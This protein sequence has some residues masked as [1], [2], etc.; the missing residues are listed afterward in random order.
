MDLGCN[1]SLSV[2]RYRHHRERRIHIDRLPDSALDLQ[3]DRGLALVVA[4]DGY[5][6]QYL[7]AV[8]GAI[9]LDGYGASLARFHLASPFARSG[10]TAGWL[11]IGQDEEFIARIRKGKSMFDEFAGLN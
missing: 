2:S 5:C 3:A 6:F 10:A 11:H 9:K 4:G 1:I 8:I 7:A